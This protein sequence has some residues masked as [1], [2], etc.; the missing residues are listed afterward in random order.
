MI[1]E[2]KNKLASTEKEKVLRLTK[3]VSNWL[4]FQ[5]NDIVSPELERVLLKELK[6]SLVEV[7][8]LIYG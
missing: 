2:F 4:T 3:A 6:E 1:V 5:H 7:E 8:I